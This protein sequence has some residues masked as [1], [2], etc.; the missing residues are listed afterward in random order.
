[1]G[2]LAMVVLL[3]TSGVAVAQ[4][5]PE[6]T[7]LFEEGREL[8]KQGKHALACEK[9]EDS[10]ALDRAPGTAL[11]YG[12]C[13]EQLG[14]LRKA[15]YMF[16][17][18]ARAFERDS[19]ARAKFARA[20]A[21]AVVPRLGTLIVKIAEPA[22]PGLIVELGRQSVPAVAEISERF[23]PGEIVVSARVPGQLPFAASA[24]VVAGATVIVEIPAFG[25]SA[26]S[27]ASTASVERARRPAVVEGPRARG[28]VYLSLGIGIGGGVV[29]GM[30]GILALRAKANYDTAVGSTQCSRETGKLVCSPLGASKIDD[31]G[32]SADLATGLAIAGAVLVTGAVVLLVTAPRETLV[33]GPTATAS[34]V[35]VTLSGRF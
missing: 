23:D 32:A 11:N 10:L 28:R 4:Q 5:V 27:A 1:M 2:R 13:L 19:D 24:R 17:E 15:F 31:A 29:L 7:R 35:G 21:D 25:H 20:R 6:G 30:S 3:L 12:A 22:A 8:A 33:V 9:F 26:A 14:Q 16:D 18:A 34:S